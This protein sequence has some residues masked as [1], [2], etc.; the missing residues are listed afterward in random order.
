MT[1][2]AGDN[3]ALPNLTSA[4]SSI[5]QINQNNTNNIDEWLLLDSN[6]GF[7]RLYDPNDA[8]SSYP[9][10]KL[11]PCTM[12]TTIEQICSRLNNDLDPRTW[13]AQYH[14]DRIQ[15]L[16]PDEKPLFIQH[17]YLLSI[18]FSSVQR[19]QQEGDKHDL[20]YLIRFLSD[21]L[22]IDPKIQP[23]SLS[24]LAW[25]RKGKLIRK[26]IKRKCVIST[27]RLTVYPDA[28]T[29]P[30][31]IELQRASVEEV[32]SR[33][34]PFCLKLTVDDGKGE[35]LFMALN[36]DEEYSRWLKRLRKTTNKLP[37]IADY[38]SSHLELIPKTLFVNPK[39]A[40]LNLR[41]NNLLMRP[42]DEAVFTAGWLDDLTRFQHL[43][44][45]NLAD[46]DLKIF[47]NVIC[48]LPRI[49]DLNLASNGID[50]IPS[51]IDKL[52]NLEVLNLQS[53]RL[54]NLPDEIENLKRLRD[55][56]LDFNLFKDIPISLARLTNV[57][58]SDV[59]H[60]SLAGNHIRKLSVD[61]IQYLEHCRQLDL[62]MNQVKF[63]ENDFLLL[64]QLI[65]LTYIDLSHNYRIYELDLRSLNNLEQINCSYNNTSRLI[66][67][68]HSLKQLNA[69]HNKLK[70][71][72]V[73]TP[74]IN[75]VQLDIS[76]NEFQNLPDWLNEDN[77]SL[78][79]L[80]ADHNR[81]N[82][83]PNKFFTSSKRL[84]YIRLNH[85]RL[86]QLP[87]K[88]TNCNIE[89]L[90]LH[91]NRIEQLPV[92][93]LKNM[94]RLKI[95][96][97]SS[98]QLISLPLPNDRTDL[99]RLQE[100]YL[101]C[102]ELDDD[103]FALISRYER[104]KILYLAYNKL[105]QLD[106]VSLS[107]L[108]SLTDLNLS[109]NN[110]QSLPQTALSSMENLQGL[111]LHSNQ[112]RAIPDLRQLNSL[113]VLDLSFNAIDSA[114]IDNLFPPSLTILD[115]SGNQAI[116]IQRD[117]LK[118]LSQKTVS[119]INISGLSD[120]SSDTSLW[121]VG[122]AQSSGSRNR[123]AITTV[124]EGSFNYSAN[125]ALFA[126]F[127]GGLN[128]EVPLILK[129]KL[130]D[131]L[132]CEYEQCDQAN[133]YLKHTFLTLQKRLKTTGQR[134]G[135]ASTVV[136]IRSLTPLN[137][138]NSNV[139]S[140]TT[141]TSSS[142]SQTENNFR[143][144]LNAAN[145]GHCEAILCRSSIIHPLTRRFTI[146]HDEGEGK[147]VRKTPN[148]IINEDNAL[149]A[150]TSQTRMLGCSFL[151]PAVLPTPHIS[152]F[153]LSKNDEF[154]I[155]ANNLL[156]QHLS[157]EEAVRTIRSIH[158]PVLA[159]KKL[160]DIAQSYGAKENLAVLIV[161]F[162]FQKKIYHIPNTPYQQPRLS[163][164]Q[165]YSANTS[166]GMY[167]VL[168][169]EH[170]PIASPL[171][172]LLD[173]TG[174][175]SVGELSG[176][177]EDDSNEEH[178]SSNIHLN[179]MSEY[180]Y[181]QSDQASSS[182]DAPATLNDSTQNRLLSRS[183]RTSLLATSLTD[184][185]NLSDRRNERIFQS[186]TKLFNF[187]ASNAQPIR[188]VPSDLTI[189]SE[190]ISTSPP[191]NSLSRTKRIKNPS[192]SGDC[193]PSARTGRYR[194]KLTPPARP[195]LGYS[196][197]PKTEYSSNSDISNEGCDYDYSPAY[198][199][200]LRPVAD[201][202]LSASSSDED[203][204]DFSYVVDQMSLASTNTN[205]DCQQQSPNEFSF[206]VR[207]HYPST[208]STT[209]SAVNST[210]TSS[211]ATTNNPPPQASSLPNKIT[212]L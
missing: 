11:V 171:M 79:R 145:V 111:Y 83:L 31:V 4:F 8:S 194:K 208:S 166:S 200:G 170:S 165:T 16:R 146:P 21:R 193:P 38:S 76:S 102:N 130:P 94:H 100:L 92:N 113:K 35:A 125:D 192:L 162:N 138:I 27:S 50:S 116:N 201:A 182:S 66:L 161:R 67:N 59:S 124:N 153:I 115:L 98:N 121:T 211:S 205:T 3:A 139:Y 150:I 87:E 114:S 199:A 23:R 204:D 176:G 195:P 36:N 61:S 151:Y 17:N 74:P 158:N 99:N 63:D 180:F 110:I 183:G 69:S 131:I 37:D 189:V 93:F 15:H 97:L 44:C 39:L 108:V 143:F 56:Y 149:N 141:T 2:P 49:V 135:A 25:I 77:L 89:T 203:D 41:H 28:N 26:W 202:V 71:I 103:V 22:I 127:D 184:T 147:R 1:P 140:S 169:S 190:I 164:Q 85:N 18:G 107:K 45:L 105:E 196:K 46:N 187:P 126:M 43:T 128:N 160:V 7:I 84:Q 120:I 42:S 168:I 12:W 95:L 122:F 55:F 14:G 159:S 68:G 152:S 33:D 80:I 5:N 179:P 197:P 60:L 91:S 48:H 47:P 156:W 32:H 136:H 72:D 6:N 62:R 90:L 191:P 57:R 88:I 144:E 64:N 9:R 129:H 155:I 82:V 104:L 30:C 70:H 54:S 186:D 178:H 40:V 137:T 51:D 34:K 53:N 177:D 181:H 75:L 19:L 73:I 96:N 210:L 142:S 117:S 209:P 20:G 29:N 173:S 133:V 206:Y 175:L 157:H 112:L 86:L 172:P 188:I 185:S 65:H 106:D 167:S 163:R 198:P 212:R 109:G 81:I 24:T 13:Y 10:S 58:Y 123:L 118:S 207:K 174:Y 132:K 119:L 154:F 78:E 101:S 52:Q 134:L 148:I